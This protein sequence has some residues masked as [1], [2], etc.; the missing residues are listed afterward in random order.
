MD[1]NLLQESAAD[2]QPEM[3]LMLTQTL[4]GKTYEKKS[5]VQLSEVRLG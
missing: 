1:H 4:Q 2:F 5:M 3:P